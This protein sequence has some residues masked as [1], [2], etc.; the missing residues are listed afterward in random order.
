MKDAVLARIFTGHERS[1]RG[2]RN[3]WKD[4]L[5]TSRYALLHQLCQVRHATFGHPRV[6]ECPRRCVQTNDYYSWA[7]LRFAVLARGVRRRLHGDQE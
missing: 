6:D 4:R 7:C 1:P 5:K 3:W 2:G